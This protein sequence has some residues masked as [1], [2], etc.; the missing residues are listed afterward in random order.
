VSAVLEDLRLDVKQNGVKVEPDG[1]WQL[2]AGYATPVERQHA[3]LARH[4]GQDYLERASD[5]F[6]SWKP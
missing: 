5:F 4:I 1:R 2:V 6:R 3:I